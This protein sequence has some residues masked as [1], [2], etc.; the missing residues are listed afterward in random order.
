MLT[1]VHIY[2]W[3]CYVFL[4]RYKR[5]HGALI[6][7]RGEN[8]S[9]YSFLYSLNFYYV[10]IFPF[11]FK[12]IM[13]KLFQ[14]DKISLRKRQ[15]TPPFLRIKYGHCVWDLRQE[16]K[17]DWLMKTCITFSQLFPDWKCYIH[18]RIILKLVPQ[19]T[20]IINDVFCISFFLFL[21][22]ILFLFMYL[23]VVCH[24]CV[25]TLEGQKGGGVRF[26]GIGVMCG[27]LW[28]DQWEF[29]K[30]HLGPL[31][32]KKVFLTAEPSPQTLF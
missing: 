2:I 17:I 21:K 25:G 6:L 32:E 22:K 16:G 11:S 31:E 19:N 24:M 27:W 8:V 12:K 30:P 26:T 18:V 7:Q 29:W 13:K 4:E 10:Y 20:N 28:D 23:C 15:S 5:N 9:L 3:I 1:L 14:W